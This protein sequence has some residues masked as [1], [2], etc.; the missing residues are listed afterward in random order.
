MVEPVDEDAL[1]RLAAAHDLTLVATGK[2]GLSSLF[3]RNDSRSVFDA[4]QAVS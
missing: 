2:G 3:A 4:A 1:D